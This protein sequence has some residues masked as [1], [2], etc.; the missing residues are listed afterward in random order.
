[1]REKL[2]PTVSEQTSEFDLKPERLCLIETLIITTQRERE[3]LTQ[4]WSL[5]V[6]N[7]KVIYCEGYPS[8]VTLSDIK[9]CSSLTQMPLSAHPKTFPDYLNT[10][11]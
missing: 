2:K 1:M 3:D 6:F 9:I 8:K 11:N 10:H 7:I 5:S 4:E